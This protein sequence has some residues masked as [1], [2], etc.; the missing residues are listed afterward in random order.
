MS[1]AMP[2][3]APPP[4]LPYP[5]GVLRR[6]LRAPLLLYRLGLGDVLN[7]I[8]ILVIT[9]RGRKSGQPRFTPIEYRRHGSKIYLIS[10]WGTQTDWYQNLIADPLATL[11]LGR[12]AVSALADPVTDAAE[13]ARAINLFRRVA[14]GRYDRLLG[15]VINE[16]VS[17][18]RLPEV[19][20]R[21]TVMRLNLIPDEPTLPGVP[22]TWAWVWP[23]L[24]AALAA[25][26]L[27][28]ALRHRLLAKRRKENPA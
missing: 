3:L 22:P 10:A 28:A 20:D 27:L 26:T 25:F 6:A 19:S 5:T 7:S 16:P 2:R 13:A 12:A 23:I 1:S 18:R 11:Q 9:T 21:F 8:H 4:T 24:V 17:A 14:P 15:W